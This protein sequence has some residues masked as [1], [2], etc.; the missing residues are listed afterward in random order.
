MFT[1]T[2]GKEIVE[3]VLTFCKET[4]KHE[5]SISLSRHE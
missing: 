1:E 4:L 5:L 2:Q 3:T